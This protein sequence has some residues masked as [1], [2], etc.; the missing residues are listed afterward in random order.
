MLPHPQATS[1]DHG[2]PHTSDLTI[3][4]RGRNNF[5]AAPQK[6]S[7]Y[8]NPGKVV[9]PVW[10]KWETVCSLAA[11]FNIALKP[12]PVLFTRQKEKFEKRFTCYLKPC[13][14]GNY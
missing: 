3:E 7:P 4:R 8:K 6:R 14:K 5:T 1:T 2:G 12:Q 10:G 11:G 9:N 13:R